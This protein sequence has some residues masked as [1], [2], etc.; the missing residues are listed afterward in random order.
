[1]GACTGIGN[2]SG[3]YNVFF[4]YGAGIAVS[5]GCYNTFIGAGAGCNNTSGRLNVVLG[6]SCATTSSASVC[7]EVT[8]N[9]GIN[10]ARFQ[11]SA[12]CWTFTSDQRDKTNIQDLPLGRDFLKGVKPRKYEWNHRHTSDYHGCESSG[13]IAQELLELVEQHNAQYTG[14]VY[15]NDPENYSVSPDGL[16][17]IIV[18]A[19]KEL[20]VENQNLKLRIEQLES[21]V[22]ISSSGG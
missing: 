15:T 16:I 13:F 11:G 6:G 8:I 14:L 22:G 7:N 19:F 1:M 5:T 2:T 10:Y 4:G 17:P 3:S 21:V 18:N 9:N 20:D 12:T